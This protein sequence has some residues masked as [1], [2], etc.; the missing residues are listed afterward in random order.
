MEIDSGRKAAAYPTKNFFVRMI[1]R[2]IA[3]EDSILDLIDN[4]VDGAWK[5][6]G[7]RPSGLAIG[8]DLSK[9]RIKIEAFPNKFSIS[10]N[11]GGMSLDDAVEYAFSFGR[12][13]ADALD[14]YSIGV[15]GIGMK[16]AVFKLGSSIRI[17]STYSDSAG[18]TS[19][20]V[21]IDVR[22]WLK[23]DDPP[24][25]FDISPSSD[26]DEDGVHIEVEDLNSGAASAFGNPSF[27]Q[28]LK[29]A[30]ARDYSLH[31]SKGI[32]VFLNDEKIQGWEIEL[33]ASGD[34]K[35]VRIEY[36]DEVDGEAVHVE[37]LA[38]MGAPPPDSSDPEADG[39]LGRR[40]GWYIACNGRIVLAADKSSVSGWGTDDW[41][42]W[43]RQ[44]D[45]FL[46]IVLFSSKKATALPLTT[47]KR[48]VDVASDVY[49]RALPRMREVSKKWIS[50]TGQRKQALDRA[51][52][53]EGN[54]SPIPIQRI[55]ANKEVV[56]PRLVAQAS[57]RMA[58]INYSVP[59]AKMR[60]LAAE[61]GSINLSYKDVGLKSFQYAYD[62]LVEGE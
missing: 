35:P 38:G 36:E 33:R 11:C 44:Y 53:L 51:K 45:G 43:H 27:I 21:P 55:V 52:E 56:L 24:W 5:K 42:Q 34:F 7:S 10:D 50:Y 58:N 46:G 2:D 61:F 26:L 28:D 47:T 18:R 23:S 9:Y 3:L 57:E 8:P 25:D 13:E 54:A 15:Y 31:L 49:R 17:T 14:D 37:L 41:P 30:I 40:S 59:L 1:T 48:S 32:Q 16:R 22:S 60:E 19:F 12:R 29:R 39:G 20:Q 62:D 6:E 4:S